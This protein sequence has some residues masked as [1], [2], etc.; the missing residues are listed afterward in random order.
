MRSVMGLSYGGE[1]LRQT[2]TQKSP[3][4]RSEAA[5]TREAQSLAQKSGNPRQGNCTYR[6][7]NNGPTGQH[8]ILARLYGRRAAHRHVLFKLRRGKSLG[9][10]WNRSILF[11]REASCGGWLEMESPQF[12]GRLS[13]EEASHGTGARFTRL[14]SDDLPRC[15]RDLRRTASGEPRASLGATTRSFVRFRRRLCG[16]SSP[17]APPSHGGTGALTRTGPFRRSGLGRGCFAA[18]VTRVIREVAALSL[19]GTRLRRRFA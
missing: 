4:L 15:C 17:P 14:A 9:V 5:S 1:F 7:G 3:I 8:C 18:A 2:K 12:A 19:S 16:S 10:L 11:K 13:T 6:L